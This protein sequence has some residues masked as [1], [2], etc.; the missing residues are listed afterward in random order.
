[1]HD[2]D[3]A[4]FVGR[5]AVEKGIDVLLSAWDIL[6]DQAPRLVIA[7]DGPLAPKVAQAAR[8]RSNISYV[9]HVPPDQ[10]LMLM[11][12]AQFLVAPSVAFESFPMTIVEAFATGLPVIG[13]K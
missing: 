12:E 9:G 11:K 7:G 13:S 5:L 3:F 1:S 2:G 10:V 6:G 4:L 8:T